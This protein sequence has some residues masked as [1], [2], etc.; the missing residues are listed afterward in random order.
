MPYYTPFS[1]LAKFMANIFY[2]YLDIKL[3]IILLKLKNED[4]TLKKL[5]VTRVIR[6]Y[7][8]RIWWSI[9]LGIVI[10]GKSFIYA[11]IE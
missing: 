2:V 4:T 7:Y 3:K 6:R 5:A 1:Q 8:L 9:V 10:V 11:M